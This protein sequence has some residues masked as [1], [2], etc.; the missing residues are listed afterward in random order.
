[1]ALPPQSVEKRNVDNSDCL[2]RFL[3]T[4]LRVFSRIQLSEA[5]VGK[6][7]R[8]VSHPARANQR[9]AEPDAF[10]DKIDDGVAKDAA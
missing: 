2:A 10:V 5:G 7:D 9:G 1:M 6:C 8:I 4:Q 3:A